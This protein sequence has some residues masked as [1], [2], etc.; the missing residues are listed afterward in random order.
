MQIEDLAAIPDMVAGAIS[1]EINLEPVFPSEPS[2]FFWLHRGDFSEKTS[3]ITLWLT[4]TKKP[5]KKI[6]CSI[7]SIANSGN[8]TVSIFHFHNSK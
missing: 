1:E 4:D 7:D 6:F 5:L 3:F 8:T 2:K